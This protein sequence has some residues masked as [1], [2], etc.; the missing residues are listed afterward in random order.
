MKLSCV[1]RVAQLA[2]YAVPPAGAPCDLR[3]D[4]N[5]GR[6][7]D[8]DWAATLTEP[9][10]ARSYPKVADL[11]ARLAAR[12]GVAADQVLVSAGADE[13]LDRACRVLLDASRGIVL[14][15]PTFEMLHTYARLAEARI[16]T[17][18]WASGPYPEEAVLDAM[19]DA[20]VAVAIVSPNNP[21]GAVASRATLE[22]V[23][24]RAP[25]V[26]LDHAYVEFADD[27]LTARGLE[28][29]N[30]L[31]FRTLSKAWGLAGLRVGYAVG[32]ADVIEWMRR[33]GLPY[34]VSGLS[35]RV[36]LDQLERQG[37]DVRDF[38]AKV[39]ARRTALEAHLRTLGLAPEPSQANFVFLRHP[40]AEGVRQGLA[41]HGIA[42]RGWP[43]HARLSDALRITVPATEADQRRLLG[44]L[45]AI[46]ATS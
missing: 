46:L 6:V 31:V 40:D 36:A 45:D 13:A 8:A 33:V 27:D 29:G 20:T 37:D 18:P 25:L 17:V 19:D 1:D 23:A 28:L 2:P 22:R 14:P 44:A 42:V 32:P 7:P 30:V 35:I 4:G 24:A 16:A 34:P 43:G 38:V 3:L 10:L 5:E 9:T 39:R 15:V 26:L 41:T 11:Q 12:H 21:T